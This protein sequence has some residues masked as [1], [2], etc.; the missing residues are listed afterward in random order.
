MRHS[1]L[2]APACFGILLFGSAVSSL[3]A[4]YQGHAVH[5]SRVIIVWEDTTKQRQLNVNQYGAFSSIKKHGYLKNIEL[6]DTHYSTSIAQNLKILSAIPGVKAVY[7]DYEIHALTQS[8]TPTDTP[9]LSTA[10]NDPDYSLLWGLN[11]PDDF[12]INAEEAWAYSTGSSQ[13]YVGVIDSGVDYTHEDLAA[14]VWT[15]PDE[16][17]GNGIDDDANGWVDDVHGIDTSA[18]DSDPM[19]EGG[20]GTHVAGTI[21]GVGNNGIG[22]TGVNWTSQI[23]P[24]RFLDANGE[25]YASGAIECL[26]YM[27]SLK[28]DKGLNLVATNNSWG[29]G[30]YSALMEE[31]IS[32]HNSLGILFVAA[33]GNEGTNI[34]SQPSYPA[35]YDIANIISVAA[36]DHNGN[37]AYFSN[38]GNSVDIAAPGVEIYSSVPGNNYESYS[39]TSMAAPH[40]TG[41]LAL[42]KAAHPD[43]SSNGLKSLL[44]TNASDKDLYDGE[45]R[46]GRLQLFNP[47]GDGAINCGDTTTITRVAPSSSSV[48]IIYQDTLAVHFASLNCGEPSDT[49]TLNYQDTSI[50]LMDNGIGSDN[51]ANDGIFSGEIEASWI[52]TI[53]I[54]V[55]GASDQSFSITS[56]RFPSITE[57]NYQFESIDNPTELNLGDDDLETIEL[58]FSITT[59]FGTTNTITVSSNGL[60]FGDSGASSVYTNTLLP[61]L[62]VNHVFAPFWDDLYNSSGSYTWEV[63][64][65]TPNRK[66]VINYTNIHFYYGNE[67]VSFQVVFNESTPIVY[68]NYAN[69]I[70]SDSHSGGST[71]TVGVEDSGY[72][73]TYSYNTYALHDNMSLL[74][75]DLEQIDLPVIDSLTYSGIPRVG[76]P[77]SLVATL[78]DNSS[79]E[80]R[81]R[82]NVGDGNGFQPYRSGSV[83]TVVYSTAGVYTVI[84]EAS[85]ET[86]SQSSSLNI[87]I[88]SISD[89]E[90]ALIDRAQ[91]D[92]LTTIQNS[93]GNFD[94]VSTATAQSMANNAASA[95][96]EAIIANPSAVGL[97]SQQAADA[98]SQQAAALA[99]QATLAALA[100]NP[101]EFGMMT[102]ENAA[103][104]TQ[105]A[106]QAI[107][108]APQDWGLSV[109][110]TTPDD[111]STLST[112]TFLVGASTDIE[113]LTAFFSDV[114]FVW[115]F[116]DGLFKGWSPDN[117]LRSQLENSGYTLIS[118]IR[119]GQGFWVTKG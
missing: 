101:N 45:T 42:L 85:T 11:D 9:S 1:A 94:L 64:G 59:P 91:S 49:V 86:A 119:S 74:I 35:S 105:L 2:F 90:Q 22:I 102:L 50:E 48:S 106:Q 93:P 114:R 33:S 44:L 103:N 79:E 63:K 92:L 70:T 39:G 60:L 118:R 115:V 77:V 107:L 20:H 31:V 111:I 15:N 95:R 83:T 71:A 87:S 89:T 4:N 84:A 21:A 97:V 7:P 96:E 43:V 12:D 98:A 66:L 72:G 36:I 6:V 110:A 76:Y 52:G 99:E 88:L 53:N 13:V 26:D 82:I 14:N 27:A 109:I 73:V 29:G 65:T 38:Y 37:F 75:G 41:A 116:E 5:D 30:G 8:D 10:P 55:V 17:A 80:T 81:M 108:D 3:A 34:D 100:D 113:D 23:I 67:P 57:V 61:S 68:Y 62:G 46:Y 25:G 69:I 78:S 54:D 19:D 32:V 28:I 104:Q 24:C 40:V 58:D 47:E 16:I 18:N 112:G 117:T 56:T 51:I